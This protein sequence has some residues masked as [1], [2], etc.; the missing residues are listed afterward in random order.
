MPEAE[1]V[2]V[3]VVATGQPIAASQSTHALNLGV[4]HQIGSPLPGSDSDRLVS[5]LDQ[6]PVCVFERCIADL[7]VWGPNRS[8]F[9]RSLEIVIKVQLRLDLVTINIQLSQSVSIMQGEL[10]RSST[11]SVQH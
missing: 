10:F 5:K 6:L 4:E 11:S 2:T 7:L 3:E 1:L 8:E 9:Q